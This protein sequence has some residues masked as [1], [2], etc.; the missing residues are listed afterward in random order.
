MAYWVGAWHMGAWSTVR[1]VACWEGVRPDWTL[2][3][4]LGAWPTGCVAYQEGTYLP[5]GVASLGRGRGLSGRGRGQMGVGMAC[6]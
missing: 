5:G 6:R 4:L 1:G 3:D 2:K